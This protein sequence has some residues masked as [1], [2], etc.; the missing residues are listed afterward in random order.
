[1][2]QERA[3][4]IASYLKTRGFDVTA[5]E[6]HEF[7]RDEYLPPSVIGED[8]DEA[9]DDALLEALEEVS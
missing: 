7:E 5:E 8:Y 2:T 6:V 9:R 3:E 1:M 4:R